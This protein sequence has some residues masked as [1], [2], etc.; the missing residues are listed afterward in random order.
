MSKGLRWT[1]T[2]IP[3]VNSKW[4][5]IGLP[6]TGFRKTIADTQPEYSHYDKRRRNQHRM[7][8]RQ[9]RRRRHRRRH[10]KSRTI[11]GP[12]SAQEKECVICAW[13]RDDILRAEIQ[14]DCLIWGVGHIVWY[15]WEEIRECGDV[16]SE[17]ER[18]VGGV[19]R[20]ATW[21]ARHREPYTRGEEVGS[22]YFDIMGKIAEY[23]ENRISKGG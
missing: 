12:F 5:C 22:L 13:K 2:R 9:R 11:H 10:T 6:D 21:V 14:R 16:R 1:L 7:R 20:K 17:I 18:R 23:S 3:A 19:V 8:R 4:L 15:A